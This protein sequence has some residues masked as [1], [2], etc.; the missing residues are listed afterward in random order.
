MAPARGRVNMVIGLQKFDDRTD[1]LNIAMLPMKKLI[2]Y[3][4]WGIAFG[5][6]DESVVRQEMEDYHPH[7][8][9]TIFVSNCYYGIKG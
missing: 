1:I 5:L 4:W 3:R 6:M 8:R 2:M 7:T 9:V